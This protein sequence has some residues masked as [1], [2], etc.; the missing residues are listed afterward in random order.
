MNGIGS[1][2]RAGDFPRNRSALQRVSSYPLLRLKGDTHER[3]QV[4][5]TERGPVGSGAGLILKVREKVVA[6]NGPF[7]L[8][9]CQIVALMF[10]HRSVVAG[11]LDELL[12][13]MVLPPCV[14]SR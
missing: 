10:P 1:P 13:T 8:M 9:F 6:K 11:R 14:T 4:V 2:R 5:E 3:L 12:V 7:S